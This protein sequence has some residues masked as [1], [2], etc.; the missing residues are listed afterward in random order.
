MKHISQIIKCLNLDSLAAGIGRWQFIPQKG[1]KEEGTQID[2]IIDRFDKSMNMCEIK[3]SNEQYRINKNDGKKNLANKIKVF[4]LKTRSQKQL[5]LTFI[6]TMGIKKN[7]WSEDLV[8]SEV[9][10]SDLFM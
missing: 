4:E 2:L 9:T 8:D 7:I 6:T 10:L 3:F 5:F 1:S